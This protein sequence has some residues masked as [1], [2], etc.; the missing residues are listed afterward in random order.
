MSREQA[1]LLS[2]A[3]RKKLVVKFSRPFEP[4]T[5]WGYVLDIGPKFFLMATF[6]D[7]FTF[8]GFECLM[9]SDVRHLKVPDPNASVAE[10][11]LR[12]RRQKVPSK[13]R[14]DLK[15]VQRLLLSANKAFPLVTVYR[16]RVDPEVCYIGRL[17]AVENGYFWLLELGPDARWEKEPTRYRLRDIT[18]VDFGGDYETGLHSVAGSV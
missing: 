17:I 2:L 9:Q 8:D 1:S 5:V 3:L 6:G 14:V 13:P 12:K 18:R 7:G 11:V 15:S 16:E 10:A 4:G